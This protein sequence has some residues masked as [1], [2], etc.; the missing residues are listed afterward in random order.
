M[1]KEDIDDREMVKVVSGGD[2]QNFSVEES[3]VVKCGMQRMQTWGT[4]RRVTARNDIQ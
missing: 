2:C 4:L 3:R 1:V